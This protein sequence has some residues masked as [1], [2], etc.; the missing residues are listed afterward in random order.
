MKGT[1]ALKISQ[2]VD[3]GEFQITEDVLD[4]SNE[5]KCMIVES[6]MVRFPITP[7]HLLFN[8]SSTD[9]L[10]VPLTGERELIVLNEF[11]ND[12]FPLSSLDVLDSTYLGK[13][14]SELPEFDQKMM[15]EYEMHMMIIDEAGSSP[16]AIKAF[17]KR[18]EWG[19]I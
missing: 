4:F 2:M 8:G 19:L 6:M 13:K 1:V 14:F 11:F 7:I 3:R 5:E 12:K 18:L 15:S 10:F 17:M 16:V 9:S